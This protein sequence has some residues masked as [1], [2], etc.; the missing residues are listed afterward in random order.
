MEHRLE[1]AYGEGNAE[2]PVTIYYGVNFFTHLSLR[3]PQGRGN[4]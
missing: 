1:R 4:P 2:V 3:A